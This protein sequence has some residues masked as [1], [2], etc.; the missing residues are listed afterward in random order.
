MQIYT[1]NFCFA[2]LGAIYFLSSVFQ[3]LVTKFLDASCFS[4][5]ILPKLI[6]KIYTYK[7]N[8]PLIDIGWPKANIKANQLNQK[9]IR[10]YLTKYSMPLQFLRRGLRDKAIFLI[11]LHFQLL[12]KPL[13][14][15]WIYQDLILFR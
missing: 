5:K 11:R 14:P 4:T 1:D 8:A 3:I 7:T 6:G 15:V 10:V 12:F 9:F 13:R 2:D